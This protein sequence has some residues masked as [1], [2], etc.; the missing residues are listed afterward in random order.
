[1]AGWEGYNFPLPKNGRD[2]LIG[3]DQRF[4]GLD[5]T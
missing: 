1:M 3:D 5:N 4:F 2:L